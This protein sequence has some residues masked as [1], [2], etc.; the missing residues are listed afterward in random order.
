MAALAGC[1]PLVTLPAVAQNQP[2]ST[3]QGALLEDPKSA[4]VEIVGHVLEPAQ[5]EPTDE[6]LARLNL[7]EGFEIGVFARDLI[8]PRMIAV[9]DDGTVYVTRR[10]V[11]DVVM[12]RDEDGDGAAETQHRRAVP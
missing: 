10:A 2:G 9:A 7:P 12:L 3:A 11:G 6:R 4:S 8:N 1:I 5:L